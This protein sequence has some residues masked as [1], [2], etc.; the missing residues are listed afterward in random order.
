MTGATVFAGPGRGAG[1]SGR[2]GADGAFLLRSIPAAAP[3]D[4][5]A[6]SP[7]FV[8]GRWPQKP[9]R[10]GEERDLGDLWLDPSAEVRFHVRDLDGDAPLEGALVE[11][12]RTNPLL[13]G[14]GVLD[15]LRAMG[16]TVEAAARATTGAEG[17]AILRDLPAGTWSFVATKEGYAPAIPEGRGTG[18]QDHEL[19]GVVSPTVFTL[20]LARGHSLA[21]RVLDARGDPVAGARVLAGQGLDGAPAAAAFRATADGLGRFRFPALPSGEVWLRVSRNG[22]AVVRGPRV[23]IPFAGEIDIVLRPGGVLA[24]TVYDADTGRPVEGAL[25]LARGVGDAESVTDA[26]GR[27]SIEELPEGTI[28]VLAVS[29]EG[30][31]TTEEPTVAGIPLRRRPLVPWVQGRYRPDLPIRGGETTWHDLLLRRGAALRGVVRGPDGPVPWARVLLVSEPSA[32]GGFPIPGTMAD[33]AGRYRFPSLPPG[34]VL[35]AVEKEGWWQPDFPRG[36]EW[37]GALRTGGPATP[38]RVAI[39]AEGEVAFD[40]VLTPGVLLEGRVLRTDGN[41]F[42]GARVV[43]LQVP[44]GAAI[45]RAAAGADGLFRFEG[46]VPGCRASLWAE[47]DGWY[48]ENGSLEVELPAEGLAAPVVLRLGRGGTV[49]GRITSATGLSLEGASVSLAVEPGRRDSGRLVGEW[50]GPHPIG[51]DGT[52]EATVPAAP[53]PG[54]FSVIARARGHQEARSRTREVMAPGEEHRVDLVLEEAH[55][56]KGR[57][58]ARDGGLPVAGARVGSGYR[59]D[60][61]LAVSDRDGRFAL[62]DLEGRNAVYHGPG[63]G[64][65]LVTV[66]ADGFL[67]AKVPVPLASHGDLRVELDRRD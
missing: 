46:L 2:S 22:N 57:V 28:T 14:E 56:I 52:Y 29:K 54:T 25:V 50:I 39:P 31:S 15:R 44:R 51:P 41:A 10:D 33:G 60:L 38:C 27:Y 7:G 23:R 18:R 32:G 11:A 48:V 55:R 59:T 1:V 34:P 24:G 9:L 8:G 61:V 67:P 43:A 17:T 30:W 40:P 53:G 4:V 58:V 63:Q 62:E 21:G 45:R 64:E 65:Y 5:G 26:E 6:S 49:R 13:G 3:F 42:P 20:R 66:Q 36:G 12:F 47:E 35:V 16:R 19:P 37:A